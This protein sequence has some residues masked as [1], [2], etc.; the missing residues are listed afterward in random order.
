MRRCVPVLGLWLCLIGSAW[1][2]EGQEW[3]LSFSPPVGAVFQYR[4]TLDLDISQ[5][6]TFLIINGVR[7]IKVLKKTED[8]EFVV[9]SRV[10]QATAKINDRELPQVKMPVAQITVRPNGASV[11]SE[12]HLEGN[13]VRGLSLPTW[14]V[15]YPDKP[16]KVGDKWE[17]NLP[18][19]ERELP[20]KGQYELVGVDRVK[21][22]EALK[23]RVSVRRLKPEASD[24]SRAEGF[25]WVDPRDGTLVKLEMHY[26][27]WAVGV[28]IPVEA[29]QQ[30]EQL[31]RD[32]KAL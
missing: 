31:E 22:R 27:H 13:P 7:V 8:G 19:H 12:A 21:N 10:E 24:E 5:Q 16:V 30:M 14:V 4:F 26:R 32:E 23:I 2:P 25:V 17:G 1:A 28:P 15:I 9:E 11:K 29:K 20:L 6:D 3:R 18:G